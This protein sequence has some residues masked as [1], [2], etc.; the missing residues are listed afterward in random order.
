MRIVEN[1]MKGEEF[2]IIMKKE[3]TEF[4]KHVDRVKKQYISVKSMKENLPT[5]HVLIQMDFSEN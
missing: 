1:E 3:F 2:V 4:G 5:N